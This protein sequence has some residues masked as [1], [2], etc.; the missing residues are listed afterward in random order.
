M[1]FTWHLLF[2]ATNVFIFSGMK[3]CI[4]SRPPILND[5]SGPTVYSYDLPKDKPDM[6]TFPAYTIR[7]KTEHVRGKANQ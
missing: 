4:E 5:L 7:Q 2:Y 6:T 3:F 1:V